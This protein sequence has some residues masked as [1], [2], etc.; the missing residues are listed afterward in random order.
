MTERGRGERSK[1]LCAGIAAQDIIMRVKQFPAAGTK[2]AAG[3][4]VITGGRLRGQCLNCC[5][6]AQRARGIRRAARVHQRRGK[7]PHRRLA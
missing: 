5:C 1:I 6:A 2:V 3:D 7:Q 4:Y